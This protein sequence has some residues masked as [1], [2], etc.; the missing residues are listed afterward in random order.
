M[1]E[2]AK[3]MDIVLH[4]YWQQVRWSIC[5]E[6]ALPFFLLLYKHNSHKSTHLFFLPGVRS[7]LI[8]LR[9]KQFQP[10]DL[11]RIAKI[12]IQTIPNLM[13]TGVGKCLDGSHHPTKKGIFHPQQISGKVM[14]STNP[15]KGTSIPTPG[16]TIWWINH[17]ACRSI[18]TAK[19][20]WLAGKCNFNVR[21]NSQMSRSS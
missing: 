6:N 14:C 20:T 3:S 18:S 11:P 5:F 16:S 2:T 12:F 8:Y 15:Q 9:R 21:Y 1:A 17:R 7:F 19:R 4:G 13:N 10:C